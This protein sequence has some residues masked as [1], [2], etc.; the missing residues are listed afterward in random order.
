M[1]QL[2]LLDLSDQP[3]PAPS[4]EGRR[5]RRGGRGWTIN[6]VFRT[7]GQAHFWFLLLLFIAFLIVL[8]IR[9]FR[10]AYELATKLLSHS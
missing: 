3:A 10:V 8:A 4:D 6:R 7:V 9:E 5:R 1:Q 2:T